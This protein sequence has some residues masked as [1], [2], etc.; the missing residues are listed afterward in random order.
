MEA[1]EYQKQAMRT[2]SITDDRKRQ[3]Y[4][5]V[6]GLTSEAGEVSGILQKIYQGHDHNIDHLVK[7]CGDC[8]WMISEILQAVNVSLED[9]MT[10]NIAKLRARYP[11]GFDHD[12]SLHRKP[13]DI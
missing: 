9:C 3:L 13:G 12:K 8:L 10:A 11:D 6:L 7:E 5:G 1:N 4:H 2:C